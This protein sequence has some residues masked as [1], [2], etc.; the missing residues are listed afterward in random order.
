[1]NSEQC[2]EAD[3]FQTTTTTDEVSVGQ[4]RVRLEISF[5]LSISR[6]DDPQHMPDTMNLCET[7]FL[8]TV[9]EPCLHIKN[10]SELLES[11][12]DNVS[13]VETWVLEKLLRLSK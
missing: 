9:N 11:I 10:R 1:M 6:D 7:H 12:E 13:L 8:E 4:P 2:K 3:G 5:R